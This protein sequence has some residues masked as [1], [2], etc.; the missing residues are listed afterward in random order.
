MRI[1]FMYIIPTFPML[2]Q[3]PL[4]LHANHTPIRSICKTVGGDL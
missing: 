2:H 4:W 1:E 3:R